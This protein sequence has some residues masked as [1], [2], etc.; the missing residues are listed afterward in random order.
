MKEFNLSHEMF[1]AATFD[2]YEDD[3]FGYQPSSTPLVL[4]L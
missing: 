4:K 2:L 1:S 3:N